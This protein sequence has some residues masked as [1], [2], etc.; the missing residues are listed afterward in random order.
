MFVLAILLA[1]QLAGCAGKQDSGPLLHLRFDEGS[2]N[3]VRDTGG[4][5][6]ETVLAYVLTNTP[7]N[8]P[9]DPQWREQGVEGGCLL[10]DGCSNSRQPF[11]RTRLP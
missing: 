9:Q 2:G 10:F 1:A 5:A 6:G 4:S 7:Y 11:L 8:T 3:L